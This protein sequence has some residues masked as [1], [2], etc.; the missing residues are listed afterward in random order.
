MSSPT[1]RARRCGAFEISPE[2]N[3]KDG[4]LSYR[5]EYKVNSFLV[6]REGLKAL[7][8]AYTQILADERGNAVLVRK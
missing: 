6:P 7:N 4:V 1:V 8:D 5:R 3:F 2:S